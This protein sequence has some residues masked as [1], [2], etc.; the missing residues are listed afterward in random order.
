M[1]RRTKSTN[2][3]DIYVPERDR[4]RHKRGEQPHVAQEVQALDGEGAE[5]LVR[6]LMPWARDTVLSA[7]ARVPGRNRVAEPSRRAR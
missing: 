7:K 3:D 2:P 4:K 1:A 6:G 5:G